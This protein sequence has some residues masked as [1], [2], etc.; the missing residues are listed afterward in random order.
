MT[1]RR[2]ARWDRPLWGIW[3]YGADEP[4]M[5]L[6]ALWHAQARDCA[7]GYDGEPSRALLFTTRRLARAWCVE[8][9]AEW[10]AHG[11]AI[12]QA[13]RVV[14]VRVRETVRAVAA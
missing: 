8:R 13:W 1:A 10:R 14:P 2:R 6:G 4:P 12:V 9:N 7:T 3:F 11:S 5:L